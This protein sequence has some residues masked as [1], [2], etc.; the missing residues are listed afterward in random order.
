MARS[1]TARI[2]AGTVGYVLLFATLLFAGA[3][4][5]RWRRGWILL[6]VLVVAR[7]VAHL[8]IARANPDLLDERAKLPLQ[9]GQPLVD[10]V[11]LSA[12]MASIAALV[13]FTAADVWRW[14]LLPQPP[15][16]LAPLGLLLYLAGW[17]IV[18]SA[19]RANRF[20]VAVV[21]HQDERGHAVADRGPYAVVRHPMYA[22]LVLH[23]L[24]IPLWLGS[25]AGIL[26]SLVP[27]GLLVVRILVE[28]R[29]LRRTLAGYDAYRSRVRYRLIPMLW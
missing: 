15:R 7:I 3:G 20:A 27:A 22:G 14:R 28:E 18:T 12:L 2:L 6:A 5:V 4:T 16:A 1:G 17:W 11:L 10:R 8:G 23:H 29:L 19:L 9:R 13:A 26:F 21:R 24:G 25:T